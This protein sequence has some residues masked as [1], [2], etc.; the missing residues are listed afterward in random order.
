MRISSC[1]GTEMCKTK[2]VIQKRLADAEAKRAKIKDL[3]A[4][5][6]SLDEIKAAVGVPPRAALI[7]DSSWTPNRVFRKVRG[8]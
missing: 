3:V 2:A 5:R 6:K 1:P 8:L 4:Q 7:L